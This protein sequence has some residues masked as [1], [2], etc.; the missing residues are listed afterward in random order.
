MMCHV[1]SDIDICR[2]SHYNGHSK[3]GFIADKL[4][5]ITRDNL[6]LCWNV[7]GDY[8]MGENRNNHRVYRNHCIIQEFLSIHVLVCRMDS[9][10]RPIDL[11]AQRIDQCHAD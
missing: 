9:V 5:K 2:I 6:F 7:Y 3:F 11:K 4:I 8:R 10:Y 1:G